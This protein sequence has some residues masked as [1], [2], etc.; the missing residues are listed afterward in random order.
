MCARMAAAAAIG[1]KT[2]EAKEIAANMSMEGPNSSGTPVTLFVAA[3]PN[4]RT[5]T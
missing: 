5:G 2:N 1:A 3:T 4:M